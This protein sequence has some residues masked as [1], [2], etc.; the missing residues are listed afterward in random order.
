MVRVESKSYSDPLV[1]RYDQRIARVVPDGTDLSVLDES[2]DAIPELPA[3][4]GQEK[5]L[6]RLLRLRSQH[7]KSQQW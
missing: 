1:E 7:I 3:L 4:P 2:S 6:A 5:E